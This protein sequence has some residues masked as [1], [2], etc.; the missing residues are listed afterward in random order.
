[1]EAH[2]NLLTWNHTCTVD[3]TAMDDQH[4]ILLDSMN[5]LRDALAHGSSRE[6][7]SELLDRLIEFTRMHFW[8]EEQLM[9]QSGFPGLAQHRA[10]HH[11]ILAQMLQYAH[12]AQYGESAQMRPLLCSLREGFLEHVEELDRQ[13]GPWLNEQSV[14]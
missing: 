5:E 6:Q 10:E 4:G 12:R 11:S 9:E 1:M 2:V 8:S 13:Y 14:H 7:L 3:V